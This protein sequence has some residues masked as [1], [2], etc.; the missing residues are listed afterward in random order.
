MVGRSPRRARYEAHCATPEHVRPS[1]ICHCG[2]CCSYGRIRRVVG[3]AQPARIL[4]ALP[5][6]P[7][8]SLVMR[9]NALVVSI[10]LPTP[11]AAM[12]PDR[13]TCVP[14]TN[15]AEPEN[16]RVTWLLRESVTFVKAC[17]HVAYSA[18]VLSMSFSDRYSCK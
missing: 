4:E 1:R 14:F 2:L 3:F 17:G 10:L 15:R 6:A 11:N 13:Y 9:F 18:Y 5:S 16:S 7:H 12:L 8:H